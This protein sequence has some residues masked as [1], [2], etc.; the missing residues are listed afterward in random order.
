[1]SSPH[2]ELPSTVPGTAAPLLKST[3][4]PE[5]GPAA[6]AD[7]PVYPTLNYPWKKA[8]GSPRISS[9]PPLRL[10]MNA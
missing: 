6:G 5:L 7:G 10:V 4:V 2:H 9:T 1:M 8:W 3:G